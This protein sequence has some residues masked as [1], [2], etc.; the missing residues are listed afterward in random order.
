MD[1]NPNNLK[2][3]FGIGLIMSIT[4]DVRKGIFLLDKV[5]GSVCKNF[6]KEIGL[7]AKEK[8]CT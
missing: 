1:L 8:D 7:T 3:V 5:S 4:Q 6:S 2:L